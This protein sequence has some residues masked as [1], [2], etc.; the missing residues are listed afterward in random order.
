MAASVWV[1]AVATLP[2][3]SL[4]YPVRAQGPEPA[5]TNRLIDSANPY[6][7]QHAHNPVDW[8]PWGPEAIAR[9]KA[10]N[11]LIFLSIGYSTCYWCHLAERTVYADPAIAAL[12]NAWFVNIKVD[13]EER[14]DLDQV[15]MAAR[16]LLTGSGGWPNNLFLTPDLEP[17]SAT[18]HVPAEDQGGR[19]GFGGLLTLMH[20]RWEA[21]PEQLAAIGRRVH[22]E[23]TT[24]RQAEVGRG[25]AALPEPVQWLKKA[26]T[27]LERRHDSLAG[28][29]YSHDGSKFPLCPALDL[30]L[31]DYRQNGSVHS[32][33]VAAEALAAIA[34]GGI[35]DH[36]GGGVH[37]YS[38]EA[39][40]SLPHFEKMLYDNAQLLSLFAE[41]YG[42]TR[43]P[44]AG[45]MAVD[46]AWYLTGRMM[47]PDGGFYTAEDA[48][49]EGREGETYLWTH[50]QIVEL[51]GTAEAERFFALYELTP[52]PGD[53][54]GRGVLR[55]RF[56]R[57][58]TI[59]DQLEAQREVAALAP[60]RAKLL[61]ARDRR[62]QP[63]RDEKI[64]VSLNGLA[65]AGLA[66]AGRILAN[67][68]WIILA[69][70]T[71]ERIWRQAFDAE[72][73]RLSRYVFRGTARGEALL[74]DY[75]MLGLGYLALGDASGE[76]IWGNRAR[77]LANIIVERFL[78]PDGMFMTTGDDHLFVPARDV[79][80]QYAPSGT[81]A[82]FALLARLGGSEERFAQT[83]SKILERMVSMIEA[84]PDRWASLVARAASVPFAPPPLSDSLDSAAHVKAAALRERHGDQDAVV[85]TLMID[86][87]YHINANPASLDYL[88]PTTISMPRTPGAKVVYPTPK[89]FKPKFMEDIIDVYEGAVVAT[90]DLPK[91]T[92]DAEFGAAVAV[93]FQACNVQTCLLPAKVS[94]PLPR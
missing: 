51:L 8:Y 44:L 15:Y 57:S 73:S 65:I 10:E 30:L 35:H 64:V 61:S 72:T 69:K 79:G 23:L 83:A 45:A 90:I 29:F 33:Q 52:W 55:V 16:H 39:T 75:A 38:T 70:R 24:Q 47:S 37:R 5:H 4:D 53:T 19:P 7:L 13:R 25:S 3:P 87:G 49:A 50:A 77:T 59:K 76:G 28:G 60:L 56:D 34:L 92:S 94:L 22:A 80:D 91:G 26:R 1:I 12:M 88:V 78:A 27:Q 54:R 82:A 11:K 42:I 63:E 46:I 41:H 9:A 40:W 14:P 93:E 67:A 36:L 62:R 68:E 71:G 81:S 20:A 43:Q 32:L 6:L 21:N 17:I 2:G 48:E 85:V 84:A 74:E 66:S 18:G 86:P 89:T 31:A 58:G